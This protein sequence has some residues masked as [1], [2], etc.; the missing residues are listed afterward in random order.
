MTRA[1]AITVLG[2]VDK[3]DV[4]SLKSGAKD[5]KEDSYYDGY[6]AWALQNNIIELEDGNFRPSDTIT[7]E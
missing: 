6:I 1:M 3:E 7:R 5:S 2:R 4:S